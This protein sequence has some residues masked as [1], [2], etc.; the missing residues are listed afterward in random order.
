MDDY[1]LRYKMRGKG[2]DF[3]LNNTQYSLNIH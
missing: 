3:S 2:G 1:L